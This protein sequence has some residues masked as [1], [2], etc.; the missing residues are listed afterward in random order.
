MFVYPIASFAKLLFIVRILHS[1]K[2]AGNRARINDS[3]NAYARKHFFAS[4]LRYLTV[5]FALCV[6]LPTLSVIVV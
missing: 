5:T 2:C 3:K 6:I 4:N 1:K